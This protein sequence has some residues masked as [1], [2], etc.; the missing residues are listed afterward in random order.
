MEA[1][2]HS[3]LPLNPI[4]TREAPRRVAQIGNAPRPAGRCDISAHSARLAGLRSAGFGR[5]EA[6]TDARL[7]DELPG[8]VAVAVVEAPVD[9]R[10][11]L[12]LYRDEF[13]RAIDPLEAAFGGRDELPVVLVG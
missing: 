4:G 5:H 7:V 3:Q 6:A 10:E 9:V 13:R 12:A 2:T 8:A 1:N 11:I